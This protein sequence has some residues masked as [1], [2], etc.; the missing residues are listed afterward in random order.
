MILSPSMIQNLNKLS[1]APY[2]K[3]LAGILAKQIF[4]G[5][6]AFPVSD[7]FITVNAQALAVGLCFANGLSP[8]SGKYGWW[9]GI[10]AGAMHCIFV[11]CM[12]MLHGG[13]CL[14]NGGLTAAFVCLLLVPVLEHF[15]KERA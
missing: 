4:V 11:T 2:G 6:S 15:C 10:V 12:P 5:M 8:I 13:F 1:F 7:S 9:W 14:Y 3:V